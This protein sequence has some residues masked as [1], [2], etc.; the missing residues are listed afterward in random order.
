MLSKVFPNCGKFFWE[1]CGI[2]NVRINVSP[3]AY[4]HFNHLCS[5]SSGCTLVLFFLPR[6]TNAYMR[7]LL[8]VKEAGKNEQNG[9][10]VM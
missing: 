4:E 6:G 2:K 9:V 8:K 7:I 1:I 10:R 5:A 3:E